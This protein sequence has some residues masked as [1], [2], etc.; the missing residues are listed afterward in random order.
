MML[1]FSLIIT[2][3]GL[4]SW[5]ADDVFGEV[6]SLKQCKFPV[7]PEIPDGSSASETDLNESAQAVKVFAGAYQKA[8]ACIDA[9][10]SKLGDQE[11]VDQRLAANEE[12]NMRVDRLNAVVQEYNQ[13]LN[14]YKARG[15]ASNP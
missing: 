13:Q 3:V 9:A 7:T 2:L 1:K 5:L 8:L 10:E 15:S 14:A 4:V 11:T 6:L 12:Y